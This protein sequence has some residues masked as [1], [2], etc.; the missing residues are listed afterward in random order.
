VVYLVDD[1]RLVEVP[2]IRPRSPST[3]ELLSVLLDGPT[4]EEA[5]QGLRTLVPPDLEIRQVTVDDDVATIDLVGPLEQAQGSE[6]PSRGLAQIVYTV[7]QSNGVQRV[8]FALE[9]SPVEVPLGD[10][11]LTR[12]PVSRSDYPQEQ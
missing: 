4:P 3:P 6:N 12:R 9:G 7:T 1:E 8:R 2:R 11:T 10:G 5:A